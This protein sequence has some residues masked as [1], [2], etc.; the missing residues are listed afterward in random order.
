MSYWLPEGLLECFSLCSC[1][2]VLLL[3]SFWSLDLKMWPQECILGECQFGCG[4]AGEKKVVYHLRV[5]VGTQLQKS[6]HQQR[7]SERWPLWMHLWHQEMRLPHL[8]FVPLHWTLQQREQSRD[9]TAPLKSPEYLYKASVT[10]GLRWYAMLRR[11]AD[12]PL[13]LTF[14]HRRAERTSKLGTAQS[15]AAVCKGARVSESFGKCCCQHTEL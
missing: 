2:S 7:G 5:I 14:L 11:T 3:G 15:S 10:R 6:R 9:S 13:S 8:C 12:E 4:E 1:L